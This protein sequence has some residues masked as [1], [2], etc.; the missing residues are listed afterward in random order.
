M[1]TLIDYIKANSHRDFHSL[2][3][4]ELDIAAI[5]E[6]GYLSF[7][8]LVEE[9]VDA[10]GVFDLSKM[11]VNDKDDTKAS[12][13]N[14]L[15]T[16]ERVALFCAIRDSKRFNDLSLSHYVNEVDPEFE[17]QFAAMVFTIPE[18]N[19]TQMIFRGTDDS[20]IGWKEDFKLTY[21]K[22][23]AANR[24]ALSYLNA[25]LMN[26]PNKELVLSGHS[27]GG[28]LALYAAAFLASDLQEQ[29]TVIYL[30]DSPGLAEE[31]LQREGYRAIRKRL[32]VIRPQESVVGVMLYCDV[33]PRIV[34]SASFGLLQHK[35]CNWQVSLDGQFEQA[36]QASHLSKTLELVF[37]D[38]TK[39]LSKRDLKLVCDSLFDALISSGITSLNAFTLNDKAF[40]TFFQIIGSLHSLD[41][42]KKSII[43]KS[44]QQ[45]IID[46]TGY[47]KREVTEK[48]QLTLSK[49]LKKTKAKSKG[50]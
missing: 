18:I 38:W 17:K 16:K 21:M 45:L 24:S 33:K 35:T 49:Y 31:F 23:V 15:I 48:I 30:L 32:R 37:K 25:Y 41:Q 42:S 44:V 20:L 14:F 13:Y 4:N 3:L 27:K 19:H 34:K 9:S 2:P 40:V 39:Q 5:N 7:D 43:M 46:Y 22:E 50:E 1:A 28:H 10:S 11:L 47:R 8:D 29:L 6:I 36:T 26:H 12:V